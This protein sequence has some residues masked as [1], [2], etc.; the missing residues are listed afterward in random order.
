[1]NVKKI[2]V[3]RQ[4]QLLFLLLTIIILFQNNC[5]NQS[6]AY[7]N[8]LTSFVQIQAA[9]Y[10]IVIGFNSIAI[11]LVA[12][13]YSLSGS[14][15]VFTKGLKAAGFSAGISI[16][17]GLYLALYISQHEESSHLLL[18]F[19]FILAFIALYLIIKYTYNIIVI[20][21]NPILLLKI[22]NE[23]EDSEVHY[24][25]LT[26]VREF[27]INALKRK[28]HNALN[29]AVKLMSEKITDNTN[30]EEF[31][32]IMENIIDI[33]EEAAIYL[34]DES[35][36]IVFENLKTI[37]NTLSANKTKNNFMDNSRK[38]NGLL[39][40]CISRGLEKSTI[41][42]FSFYESLLDKSDSD[43]SADFSKKFRA[44]PRTEVFYKL[45]ILT[46]LIYF[47]TVACETKS[48]YLAEKSS[49]YI[50]DMLEKTLDANE[51]VNILNST[52]IDKIKILGMT[53]SDNKQNN[54]TTRIVMILTRIARNPTADNNRIKNISTIIF[55]IGK[56]S[57]F[58]CLEDCYDDSVDGLETILQS[59]QKS[60]KNTSDI[61]KNIQDMLKK[62]KNDFEC[63]GI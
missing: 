16:F 35:A 48:E 50:Y 7:G 34:D 46:P 20:S 54:T 44:L 32:E 11:Q 45:N 38:I 47:C 22:L 29:E 1:M 61:E 33:G 9:F 19:S 51:G 59:I 60:K 4:I 13:N 55:K 36:S 53:A 42:G 43:P 3:F 12:S 49:K 58:N 17:Y 24:Q 39:K 27:A 37:F 56:Q 6:N 25:V 10:A 62:L 21:L 15:K 28:D 18:V 41:N 23:K 14:G 8:F 30:D 40:M 26:R 2:N 52:I 31:K 5:D 57:K 63:F